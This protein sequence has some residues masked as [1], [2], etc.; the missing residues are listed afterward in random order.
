[1]AKN[2]SGIRGDVRQSA[3]WGSGNR[4]GELRSNALWGKGG[5]GI[6]VIMLLALSMPLAAS[7]G[8]TATGGTTVQGVT[9][10]ATH[11]DAKLL[12]EAADNPSKTVNVIIQAAGGV[13]QAE[14]ARAGAG[15]LKRT[16]G[17]VGAVAVELPAAAVQRL[18]T[19]P[20]L[21]VTHDSDI[22]ATGSYTS[23][24]LWTKE[25]GVERLWSGPQAPTI[26]VVDSG[27]DTSRLD[28]SS[29][30][31]TQVSF[32][33]SGNPNSAGDGR[34][35]GTFVA[36]IAAGSAP[37]YAGAAPNAPLVSLDVF[38]DS[39]SGRTSDVIA[40]VDW[41][42][43][44]A[45]AYNIR[46]V[47]LSLHTGRAGRFHEDPLNRAVEKLWFAGI[48]VVAASGNYGK[49]DGPSG[50]G[51]SPGNDPFI[52]TVGAVDIGGTHKLG[53]D[54]Q[55]SW[56]A[57]GPTPDGF[58]KPEIC[59]PGRYMVGPVPMSST[60]AAQRPEKIK[61]EG[62]MELSGTS[63][64]A[65]IISGVAAQLL[66][67]SPLLT[68]D[69]VKGVLMRRVRP[70]P[71]GDPRA[72][73][74]GQINAVK[75]ATDL[76]AP[77]NPNGALNVFT[78]VQLDGTRAFDAVAWSDAVALNSA[79]DTVAWS[80]VAWSDAA[81]SNVAWSD[82]AWSDVAWSDV[83]WSDVVMED[84]AEGD[85]STTLEGYL[86]TPQAAE[87]AAADPDLLMPGETLP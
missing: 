43:Q 65:P 4:G 13:E 51:Y 15:K 60:L 85:A 66:A 31:L 38:D 11:V 26:A 24:Q 44:N 70:V 10:K 61:T 3:L 9:G 59:A 49:A 6:V 29:R 30:V 33:S 50:V 35:H 5:R 47:N 83:A 84:A 42:Y 77:A 34:G 56:S 58:W 54:Q 48:V 68:P 71:Q 57:Y 62:Y 81:W 78:T 17:L 53:D 67:R 22:A 23:T 52:I 1:M 86:V 32:V 76:A 87:E 7:A 69:Q 80:D 45:G 16:L 18:A 14:R 27:V 82:I 36:G 12:Q 2:S 74:V 72:C 55:A 40:A 79:W 21:I 46:V 39:G 41:I 63:F 25:T 37:G 73:G 19:I 28:F 8:R 20:G 64:A 75:T